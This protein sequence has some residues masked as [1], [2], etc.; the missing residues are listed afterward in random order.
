MKKRGAALVCMML[1]ALLFMLAGCQDIGG[2]NLNQALLSGLDVQSYE[3]SQTVSLELNFDE[4]GE[5]VKESPELLLFKNM[6][7]VFSNIKMQ[8]QKTMSMDGELRLSKGSVPFQ[9]SMSEKQMAVTVQGA[10]KPLLIDTSYQKPDTKEPL[11]F[12]PAAFGDPNELVRKFAPFIIKHL[13]N[14]QTIQ[15]VPAVETINGDPIHMTKI[16]A[17]IKGTEIPAF[18]KAMIDSVAADEAGLTDFVQ[19]IMQLAMGDKYDP[20]L[21]AAAAGMVKQTLE[22]ASAD[23]EQQLSSS[24]AKSFLTDDNYL[25]ADLYVDSHSDIR[26]SVME[27]A[28]VSPK[29]ETSGFKG[30]KLSTTSSIWKLNEPV[31]A[32][33]IDTSKGS[34]AIDENFRTGHFLKNL[35]ENSDL[36]KLLVNDLKVTHRS[37]QMNMNDEPNEYHAVPY[38]DPVT[39]KTMLPVRFVSERLD[40]EVKWDAAKQEVTVTDI[41]SG[42]SAVF[43]IDSD[44]AVVNGNPVKLGAKAQITHGSAYVPAQ[45]IVE[46]VFGAKLNWD[47]ANRTVSIEKP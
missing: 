38:I 33:L 10:K 11:P 39:E 17:E 4:N 43:T 44:T 35:D 42:N 21:A 14:P 9:I 34:I 22:S 2:V 27:F 8:D 25:K 41:M 15:A 26:K 24:E 13:P 30:L 28:F 40:A 1:A 37:I 32:E 12:D 5:A 19:Q 3:G 6:Q 31:K 23:M 29:E 7:M 46:Q 16:H 18:I 36:Y 45:V 20:A 47:S